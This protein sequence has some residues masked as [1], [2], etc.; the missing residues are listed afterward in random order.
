M[1][2]EKHVGGGGDKNISSTTRPSTRFEYESRDLVAHCPR[3]LICRDDEIV[4]QVSPTNKTSYS[5]R[6]LPSLHPNLIEPTSI[7][8]SFH[9]LGFLLIFGLYL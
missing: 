1:K 2:L 7:F 4:Y 8:L 9:R 5:V 3:Q 6:L